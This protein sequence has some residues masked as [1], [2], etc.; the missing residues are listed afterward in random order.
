MMKKAILTIFALSVLAACNQQGV[1]LGTVGAGGGGVTPPQSTRTEFEMGGVEAPPVYRF[2][3]N[4]D[5]SPADAMAAGASVL[6]TADSNLQVTVESRTYFMRQIQ[7]NGENFVVVEG[8]APV[9]SLPGVIKTRTGCLVN[10]Q[11][12]R[13]NDAAVFTLDCS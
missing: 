6:R 7:L 2:S 8:A 11:P 5:P 4:G 9:A 13:S 12:L 1:G 3:V 10:P